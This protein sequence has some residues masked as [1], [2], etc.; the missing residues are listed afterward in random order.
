[1]ALRPRASVLLLLLPLVLLKD[2]LTLY[3]DLGPGNVH[4]KDGG[5]HKQRQLNKSKGRG[6]LRSAPTTLASE[7][8]SAHPQ[9]GPNHRPPHTYGLD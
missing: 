8:S 7:R 3:E 6:H 2:R 5:D 9:A 1:M 4:G